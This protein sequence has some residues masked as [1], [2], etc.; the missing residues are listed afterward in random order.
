MTT[1]I[2]GDQL[3]L[4]DLCNVFVSLKLECIIC[5]SQRSYDGHTMSF[6]GNMNYNYNSMGLAVC[7][8]IKSG[9]LRLK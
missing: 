7:I 9:L 1:L 8:A 2:V 6:I 3:H 5:S 4:V